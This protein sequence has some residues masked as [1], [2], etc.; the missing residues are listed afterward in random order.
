MPH[1]T[2]QHF[3]VMIFYLN[4]DYWSCEYL[5]L[6][7]VPVSGSKFH[8]VGKFVTD[9][10]LNSTRLVL[11]FNIEKWLNFQPMYKFIVTPDHI[12]LPDTDHQIKQTIRLNSTLLDKS[13]VIIMHACIYFELLGRLLH[14]ENILIKVYRNEAVSII[15]M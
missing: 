2:N 15:T 4:I 8:D 13:P 3:V 10:G 12:S 9:F 1:V 7:F 5:L 11:I 14:W 6:N